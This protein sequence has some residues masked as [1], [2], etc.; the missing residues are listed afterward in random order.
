MDS[1]EQVVATILDRSGYWVRMS[2]KVALTPE[3]K[4]EISRPS[5]PRWE[6]DIVAYSGNKNELLVVECKS[7]LDSSG[8]RTTSFDGP[9]AEDETR[10]KLFSD[11]VLRRVVLS[12]LERQL[13]E[14]GFCPTGAKATLCLAAGKIYGDPVPLRAIF[15]KN[16]WRLLES[17]W[18]VDG[19]QRLAEES[20]DNSVASIVAKLLLRNE[21]VNRIPRS[22]VAATR[23]ERLE[24]GTRRDVLIA[25]LYFSRF[26]HDALGFGNQG[27]TLQQVAAFLGMK[28]HTLRNY[29]DHFDPHTQSG[30]RGWWQA[31]LS[32]EFKDVL[33]EF[34]GSSEPEL[35]VRVLESLS[36]DGGAGESPV[37]RTRPANSTQPGFT[38]KN[39]QTVA[40]AAGLPGTDHGQSIYALRCGHCAEE[41]GANGSDIW[42]RKCPKC[43]G[44]RPGLSLVDAGNPR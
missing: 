39:G 28:K 18:L 5:S 36:R 22:G 20:Y 11:E 27:Q 33:H 7:Y 21:L 19:L 38:N 13:A 35:R 40:G 4:R 23:R 44:G 37:N 15:E 31:D 3:E 12:R 24:P 32:D 26:G 42:F 29:R 6:L 16:G 34:G 1:F 41:Y 30:R 8:V 25:A 9:K 2:V 17:S 10:Y 43:Q 14:Q